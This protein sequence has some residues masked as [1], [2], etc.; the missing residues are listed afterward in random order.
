MMSISELENHIEAYLSYLQHIRGY[1]QKTY[2]TYKSALYEA[3]ELIKLDEENGVVILNIIPFRE[4]ILNN[5]KKTISKKLSA[6]RGL[7]EY[8]ED[9]GFS[10]RI[11]GDSKIKIPKTLPKPVYSGSILEALKMANLEEK[12][13]ILLLYSLG[14]RISE[15]AN[16]KKS[17]LKGEWVRVVGKGSK[18]REVP[19]L[20]NIKSLIED[21]LKVYKPNEYIFERDGKKL[22]ENDLRYIVKEAFR[23]IGLKVTPHQ[24]RHSF[25][26]ELLNN[27]AS[28]LDIKE[29]LGHSSVS[30]TE[31]YTKLTSS[32]KL[33]SYLNA[34]PLCKEV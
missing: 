26:T 31:I 30:T 12:T 34:H 19:L 20:S 1:S 4:K 25:A 32:S 16:L 17:D 13:V 23:R 6:I 9:R 22:S 33:K 3:K 7:K 10:I 27:G 2:I 29:L 28:I 24:L 18:T 11:I 8:L 14:L 5:N 15:L 21:Y